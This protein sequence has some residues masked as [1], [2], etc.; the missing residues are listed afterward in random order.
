MPQYITYYA[1]EAGGMDAWISS[2]VRS[3]AASAG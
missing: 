1:A 2:V 3:G